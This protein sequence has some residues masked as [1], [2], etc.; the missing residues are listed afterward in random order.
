[1]L[2]FTIALFAFMVAAGTAESA[3]RAVSRHAAVRAARM[4]PAGLP[5]PHYNYRTTITFAAPYTYRRPYPRLTV[6]ENPAVL[7]AP[8]ETYLPYVRPVVIAPVYYGP[9][10]GYDDAFPYWDRLPY[11]CAVNGYC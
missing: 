9:I 5:R 11:A 8:V 10:Y 4:L 3:D 2:R 1:M 6:Y 7:Y